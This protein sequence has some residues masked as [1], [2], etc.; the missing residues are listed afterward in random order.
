MKHHYCLLSLLLPLFDH[1]LITKNSYNEYT[2]SKNKC[3]IKS[4]QNLFYSNYGFVIEDGKVQKIKIEELNLD[5]LK[6]NTNDNEYHD[7]EYGHLNFLELDN[8]IKDLITKIEEVELAKGFIVR[9]LA[10]DPYNP[11]NFKIKIERDHLTVDRNLIHLFIDRY[12]YLRLIKNKPNIQIKIF[13]SKSLN[14]NE[15]VTL[16]EIDIFIFH[17]NKDN[18]DKKL[19]SLN[20]FYYIQNLE[21]SIRKINEYLKVN[22]KVF[23]YNELIYE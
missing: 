14:D 6:T 12:R 5:S 13:A 19:I 9:E 10:K 21:E 23:S 8:P 22:K 16:T 1:L 3:K 7:N 4:L 20:Y 15:I 18:K 11:K 17:L 2:L